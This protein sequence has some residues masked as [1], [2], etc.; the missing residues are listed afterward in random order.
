MDW[1][2]VR[3]QMIHLAK[4]EFE[5]TW[6]KGTIKEY[7]MQARI[8]EYW[9]QGVYKDVSIPEYITIPGSAW[10]AAFIS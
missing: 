5:V 10:S 3:Q 2:N 6:N 4:Q 7:D 8:R 9:Q 1:E